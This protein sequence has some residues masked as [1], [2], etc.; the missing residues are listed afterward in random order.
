MQRS[1]T[2][3]MLSI[4]LLL[5]AGRTT[6]AQRVHQSGVV[7]SRTT[8]AQAQLV[9]RDGPTIPTSPPASEAAKDRSS[10][11]RYALVGAIVG[12]AAS[13]IV[14]AA[15]SAEYGPSPPV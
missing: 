12:I 11:G 2:S 10:P 15:L 8:S 6:Q 7:A 13:G 3:V 9:W 5:T 1:V 4:A 14:L